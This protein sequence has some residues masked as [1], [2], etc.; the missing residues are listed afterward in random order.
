MISSHH[1]QCVKSVRIRSYSDPYFARIRT[2]YREIRSISPYSILMQENTNR[3]K[4]E[5]GHFS[6][7]VKLLEKDNYVSSHQQNLKILAT[8]MYKVSKDSL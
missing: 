5:Y 8:E 4:S 3:N 7:N 2:E 1:L 6:C